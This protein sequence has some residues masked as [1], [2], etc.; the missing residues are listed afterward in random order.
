M[1][2]GID[3]G[4]SHISCALVNQEG[5]II[6][7]SDSYTDSKWSLDEIKETIKEL[8]FE[9]IPRL[10]DIISIGIGVPGAVNS[11]TGYVKYSA[12]LPFIDINLK[13]YF[14][15]ILNREVKIEND[16]N[17]AALGEML[18]G[19]GLNKKNIVLVTIGTGIGSGLIINGKIYSGYNGYA[20]E[21]GHHI[22]VANGRECACGNKGCLESYAS[23]KSIEKKAKELIKYYPKSILNTNRINGRS[24]YENAKLGDTLCK[25]LVKE[26][27]FYLGIG[28]SNIINIIQPEIVLISGAISK[29]KEY[30]LK[31]LKPEIDRHLYVKGTYELNTSKLE[32]KAG[33]IGAAFL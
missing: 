2:I 26:H 4:G 3:V 1:R 7:V 32:N 9:I 29:Q 27:L 8:V 14:G 33:I 11:K 31:E 30:L 13:E 25:E 23:M 19:N 21:I 16:A 18:F 17:C 15:D 20:G 24:I 6:R 10:D 28:I 22:I 12:N 5:K